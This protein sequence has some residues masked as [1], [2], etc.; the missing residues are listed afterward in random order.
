MRI[1]LARLRSLMSDQ[2]GL[3]DWLD[4]QLAKCSPDDPPFLSDLL[5]GHARGGTF[6]LEALARRY[7]DALRLSAAQ[8]E[9]TSFRWRLHVLRDEWGNKLMPGDVF[10]H[11]ETLPLQHDDGVLATSRELSA[12]KSDGT[13]NAKWTL[14]HEHPIDERGCLTVEFEHAALLL[15]LYG[16]HPQSGV[17]VGRRRPEHSAEPVETG[18]GSERL[19]VWYHRLCEADREYYAAL[20][21]LGQRGKNDRKRGEAASTQEG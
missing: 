8:R 2:R 1:D 18:N 16:R 15:S 12:D 19:H 14:L 4:S 13:Y 9:K 6:V 5:I 7:R 3:A 11:R 17:C 10:R 21:V 20:P